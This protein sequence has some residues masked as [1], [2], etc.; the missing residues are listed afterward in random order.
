VPDIAA[1]IFLT[2]HYK[3]D[4]FFVQSLFLHNFCLYLTFNH[5]FKKDKNETVTQIGDADFHWP[6]GGIMWKG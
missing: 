3:K 5:K 4:H 2:S 1:D 6:F